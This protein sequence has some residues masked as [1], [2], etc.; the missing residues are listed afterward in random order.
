MLEPYYN[1]YPFFIHPHTKLKRHAFLK[2]SDNLSLYT[3]G[4]SFLGLPVQP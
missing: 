3:T 4:S 1:F 2:K